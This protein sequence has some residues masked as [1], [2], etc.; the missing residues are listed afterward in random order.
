MNLDHYERCRWTRKKSLLLTAA[1][2]DVTAECQQKADG[3]VADGKTW[4]S[5]QSGQSGRM[6]LQFSAFNAFSLF[7]N[8]WDAF[9][10]DFTAEIF[11]E[12]EGCIESSACET[13][14]SL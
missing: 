5:G 7:F 1:K 13:P 14:S 4:Q 12:C 6:V 9:C 10:P 2:P 3:K 11:F 8:I